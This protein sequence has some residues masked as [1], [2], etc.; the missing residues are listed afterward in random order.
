MTAV[1]PPHIKLESIFGDYQN[2]YVSP[3]ENS[4]LNFKLGSNMK[5]EQEKLNN[6]LS[7]TTVGLLIMQIIISIIM[8][9]SIRNLVAKNQLLIST[10]NTEEEFQIFGESLSDF[11]LRDVNDQ[12]FKLSNLAG[13]PI[14]LVFS[15]HDCGSC[16]TLYPNLVNFSR[17]YPQYKIVVV[18]SNSL[19]ENQAFIQEYDEDRELPWIVLQGTKMV[20]EQ[21]QI[22]A[23]PTL[24]F[25]DA[26]GK[27]ANANHAIT[28]EQIVELVNR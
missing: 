22:S 13:S 28:K 25:V 15:S 21:Y 8:L 5:S 3:F 24:L 18:T 10:H 6:I 26:N 27:I 17:S 12:L 7:A 4:L 16:K 23:T 14:V 9:I 2:K 19:D 1:S 11:E 20:F